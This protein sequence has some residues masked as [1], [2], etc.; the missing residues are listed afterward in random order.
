MN[1]HKIKTFKDLEAW[2]AGHKLVLM[3]YR[4][5]KAFPRVELFGLINQLRRAAV[6]VTSNVAEGFSRR[7]DKEKTQFF[8]MACG[9]ITEIQ[10]QLEV[11]KDVGYIE[12]KDY[13]AIN[14]QSE[15]VHRLIRGMLRY[16]KAKNI[17]FMAVLIL[18]LIL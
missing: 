18:A 11:S 15:S 5:T 7:S 6:S 12:R 10:N 3:I 17:V 14:E 2:K 13:T 8:S 16:I 9:S 4:V 1:A